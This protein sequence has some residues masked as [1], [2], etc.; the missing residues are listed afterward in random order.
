MIKEYV[1]KER[2][3]TWWFYFSFGVTLA[4]RRRELLPDQTPLL[5]FSLAG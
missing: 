1:K 5:A 2:K 3:V 4:P